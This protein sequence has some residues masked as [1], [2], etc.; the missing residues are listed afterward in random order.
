MTEH[1]PP[2]LSLPSTLQ[3]LRRR[4]RVVLLCLALVPATALALSLLQTKEY[5]ATASLLFRDPGFAQQL[6]GS[7][8]GNQPKDPAREAATNVELVSL[9]EVARRTARKL[10]NGLTATDVSAMIE[11][12]AQ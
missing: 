4:L 11:V 2:K 1:G 7:S 12:E 10:G 3:V 9:A 5:T 8:V 6:F